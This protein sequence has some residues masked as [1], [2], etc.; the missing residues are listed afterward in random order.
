MKKTIWLFIVF[1]VF[2]GYLSG[3]SF[4]TSADLDGD[5][6]T[7][8]SQF[9]YEFR[10]IVQN[11][12]TDSIYIS[13]DVDLSASFL[14]PGWNAG[15]CD[16]VN[17]YAYNGSVH[18]SDKIGR[19][20]AATWSLNIDP[21]AG[22]DGTGWVTEVLTD[23]HNTT[24]KTVVFILSKLPSG[25]V[26]VPSQGEDVVIYP[27][28]SSSVVNVIAPHPVNVSIMDVAGKTLLYQHSTTRIDIGDLASGIY[29]IQIYDQHN[30]P[31]KTG[32]LIKE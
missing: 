7:A 25:V 27:N 10:N 13:W 1:L 8:S 11:T 24:T 32:K 4:K 22:A 23:N 19:G 14:P 29:V 3:Q 18:H 5:T 9:S 28:P 15:P 12:F 17:C 21:S 2:G 30:I 20:A 16:N 6:L 31:V 26:C